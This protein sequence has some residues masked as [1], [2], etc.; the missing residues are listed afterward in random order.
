MTLSGPTVGRQANYLPLELRRE[1][2]PSH[3]TPSVRHS[4]LSEVSGNTG[5]VQIADWV[6]TGSHSIGSRRPLWLLEQIL[7][8]SLWRP[9]LQRRAICFFAPSETSNPI[10]PS[11]VPNLWPNPAPNLDARRS[12][13]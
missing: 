7:R 11:C 9:S 8:V 10:R 6:T 4:R 5:N 2:T 12:A 13:I 1:R 3:G